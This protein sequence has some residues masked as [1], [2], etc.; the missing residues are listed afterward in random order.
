MRH[1]PQIAASLDP[2]ATALA[3][4]NHSRDAGSASGV[5]GLTQFAIGATAAPLVGVAGPRDDLPMAIVIC[6]LGASALSSRFLARRPAPAE[7]EKE[8][9]TQA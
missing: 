7:P 1:V 2:S 9:Q 6:V 8:R 5:L 4:E 3:L